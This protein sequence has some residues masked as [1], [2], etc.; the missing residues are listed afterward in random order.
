MIL[1][2]GEKLLLNDEARLFNDEN[3]TLGVL[4]LT[5]LRIVFEAGVGGAS[6]YTAY[7]ETLERVWNAHAGSSSK[8]FEGYREYLT[9]EGDRRRVV[10][11]V[12][13]AVGW[14][15]A[16]TELKQNSPPIPPP[17]ARARPSYPTTAVPGQVVV[18]IPAQEAPKIMMHCRHCGNLYDAT[19]GRCDKCGAPPT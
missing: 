17:P 10:F 16:I 2:R 6:P 12:A 3:G 18:N 9:I 11:E 19:K 13:G 1:A 14:V 7:N 5:N 15:N 4:S 8:L